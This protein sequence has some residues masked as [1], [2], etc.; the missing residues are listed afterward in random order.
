MCSPQIMEVVRKRLEKEGPPS[1]SRRNLLKLGG[2]LAAGAAVVASSPLRVLGQDMMHEV[3]DL[4]H[5]MGESSP[6]IFGPDFAPVR[7]KIEFLSEV[8]HWQQWSFN[9]HSGTHVDVPSH[10]ILDGGENVDTYDANLLVSPA[11]VIDISARA[12]EDAD[13][14]VTVE[15]IQ[16]WESMNGEVPPDA[17]VCMHSGWEAHWGNPASF[18]NRDDDGVAHF[19][20]SARRRP[21]SWWRNAT[22]TAS[23]WTRRART[24]ATPRPSPC[25]TS[26][27]RGPLRR[28]ERA[29]PGGHQGPRG[30]SGC[31]RAALGGRLR[32]SLPRAGND[33]SGSRQKRPLQAPFPARERGLFHDSPASPRNRN[34]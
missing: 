11:V 23:P 14:F 7:E 20:D 16:A 26:R 9:E 8:I 17:L 24:P 5:V 22:S 1:M 3:V 2:G 31:G 27:W 10:F 18:V 6:H 30:A 21:P 32:R 4:S 33:L 25:T 34:T 28:G 29:Q 15:D 13:A 12:A 19:P